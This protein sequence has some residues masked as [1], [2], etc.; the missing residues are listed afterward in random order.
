M[1]MGCLIKGGMKALYDDV[2]FGGHPL[3]ELRGLQQGPPPNARGAWNN[4]LV[5]FLGPQLMKIAQKGDKVILMRRDY[6]EV[7][8]SHQGHG[9][10]IEIDRFRYK[11]RFVRIEQQLR[12][13]GVDVLS[14]WYPAVVDNPLAAFKM[15]ERNGWPIDPDQAALYVDRKMYRYKE[16]AKAEMAMETLL[17]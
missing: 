13:A 1:M 4:R 3:Y 8:R 11:K 5:K 17:Q 16:P 10:K 14:L 7:L 2:E 15:L 9:M 6:D 12:D